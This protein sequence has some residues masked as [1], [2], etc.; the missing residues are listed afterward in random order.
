MEEK[1]KIKVEGEIILTANDGWYFLSN[2]GTLYSS[3]V[4]SSIDEILETESSVGERFRI[5]I[6][7]LGEN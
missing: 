4:C 7:R 1:T 6:E 2:D 5:T 3:T